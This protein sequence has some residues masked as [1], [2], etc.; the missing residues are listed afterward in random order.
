MQANEELIAER[1]L[2]LQLERAQFLERLLVPNE[3]RGHF[4]TPAPLVMVLDATTARIHWEV[5]AQSDLD[6]PSPDDSDD[7][8]ARNG[9]GIGIEGGG[10]PALLLGDVEELHPPTAD[11]LRITARNHHHRP[12]VCCGCWWSPTRR[13]TPPLPGA[14]AEGEAVADLLE[15]FNTTWAHS[16][17][18]ISVER[19]IGPEMATRTEV[20][21]RLMLR[22]Y[23]VLHFAGHCS[24]DPEHPRACG[25][26][27]SNGQTLSAKELT[28]V[29]RVPAFVFSN[30][31]ESGIT[32]DRSEEESAAMAPSFAESFFARGVANFVCTAW[33]V[34]DNAAVAFAQRLV[35]QPA[36]RGD[37]RRR[38]QRVH[39][40]RTP[41][42]AHRDATSSPRDRRDAGRRP[43]LG[44]VPALRR[45]APPFPGS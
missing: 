11:E 14:R 1:D 29:D 42:D 17:N 20:L 35:R 26:V 15:A 37:A 41:A 3:L 25:W 38:S 16:E 22:S 13:P 9:T 32:P 27:F 2:T 39:G 33:P 44:C 36:R 31:C 28:R 24:F 45:P 19:L 18:R 8:A 12:D 10:R 5:I 23:D 4:F 40:E 30:V 6:D 43:H 21:R 34:D 7:D